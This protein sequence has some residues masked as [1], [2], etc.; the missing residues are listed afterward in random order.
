MPLVKGK[1]SKIKQEHRLV[2]FCSFLFPS[3]FNSVK[4]TNWLRKE[5]NRLLKKGMFL[6][7][8]KK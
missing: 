7:Q 1:T 5:I 4:K 2:E 8:L 3:F 6:I